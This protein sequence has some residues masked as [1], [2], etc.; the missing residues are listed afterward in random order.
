LSIYKDS[1]LLISQLLIFII[2]LFTVF[3]N[4]WGSDPMMVILVLLAKWIGLDVSEMDFGRSLIYSFKKKK[5]RRT[6]YGAL[7][8]TITNWLPFGEI[9]PWFVIYY[10]SLESIF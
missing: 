10:Y 1:K 4:S 9:L 7:R 5:K 8:N 3:E 2:L 6:K